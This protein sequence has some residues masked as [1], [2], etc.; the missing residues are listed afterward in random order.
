MATDKHSG[1]SSK[2]STKSPAKSASKAEHKSASSGNH[3][4]H[5]TQASAEGRK[6]VAKQGSKK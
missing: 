2:S 4:G 1:T 3:E 5:A 6:H